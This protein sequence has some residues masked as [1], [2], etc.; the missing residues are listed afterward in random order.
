[1]IIVWIL[2]IFGAIS[3][4]LYLLLWRVCDE[5]DYKEEFGEEFVEDD[6]FE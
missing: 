5:H 3:L 6:I 1:M 2:A 4:L